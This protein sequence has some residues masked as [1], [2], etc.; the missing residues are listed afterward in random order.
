MSLAV[1]ALNFAG[2][3]GARGFVTVAGGRDVECRFSS[4]EAT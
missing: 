1:A 3:L 2:G 4:P